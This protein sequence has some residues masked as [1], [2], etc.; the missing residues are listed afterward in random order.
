MPPKFT[1]AERTRITDALLSAG[2]ELFTTQGLRKTSMDELA[3][4]AGIAKSSFYVFFESKEH[5]YHELLIR[6]APEIGRKWVPVAHET[7]DAY[8]GVI[9]MFTNGWETAATDP[10]YRRLLNHP[11]D[12]EMVHRRVLTDDEHERIRPHVLEPLTE[13]IE[14]WQR[15]GQLV[16][17]DPMVVIGLI[18]A[19][20]LIVQHAD[21]FG[22]QYPQVA[23][24]LK[25]VVATGLT[26]AQSK[27]NQ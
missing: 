23:E 25:H 4:R 21:E 19:V 17:A 22:D 6:Q 16:D 15:E 2:Y 27:G 20:S 7:P 14:Y 3:G 11:E 1:D 8:T 5:L 18:R 24:L 26:T 9:N 13:F 12:L 10:L